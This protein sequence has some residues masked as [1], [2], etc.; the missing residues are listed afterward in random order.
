MLG[1]KQILKR[2]SDA[3]CK[4]ASVKGETHSHYNATERVHIGSNGRR[5]LSVNYTPKSAHPKI[6][7]SQENA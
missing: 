6:R 2:V 3:T 7:K 5:S 4:V 1:H